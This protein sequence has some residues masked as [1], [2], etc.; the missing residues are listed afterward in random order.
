M[1]PSEIPRKASPR[2]WQTPSLSSGIACIGSQFQKFG[3]IRRNCQV[4]PC[5]W[6]DR[7]DTGALKATQAFAGRERLLQQVAED[8]CVIKVLSYDIQGRAGVSL[9][10]T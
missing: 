3:V 7:V 5:I 6:S 4:Q 10:L 8:F 1:R 9:R 2:H